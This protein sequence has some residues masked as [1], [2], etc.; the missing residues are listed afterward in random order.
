[1]LLSV[2]K[3]TKIRTIGEECFRIC[4]IFEVLE[5]RLKK[6]SKKREAI[7]LFIEKIHLIEVDSL[8]LSKQCRLRLIDGYSFFFLICIV[9]ILDL[10]LAYHV[11]SIFRVGPACAGR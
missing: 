3:L 2:W 6:S 9:S 11:L 1:M 4:E 5:D 8:V 10:L 7:E